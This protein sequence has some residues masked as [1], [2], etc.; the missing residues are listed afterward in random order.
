[1]P[2]SSPF[3]WFSRGRSQMKI[4][5]FA[6][7]MDKLYKLDRRG[8]MMKHWL[9]RS[10]L[11]I[12]NRLWLSTIPVIW[13]K[14]FSPLSYL[15]EIQASFFASVLSDRSFRHTS[16]KI[17]HCT[18]TSSKLKRHENSSAK[19]WFSKEN[20]PWLAAWHKI[21]FIICNWLVESTNLFGFSAVLFADF[22]RLW[23]PR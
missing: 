14:G 8:L 5:V 21:H 15:G 2:V 19:H 6:C 22:D 4:R 1:M 16:C 9:R 11:I 20:N 23:L 7:A 18:W 13:L 3:C 10:F 17:E 12:Y